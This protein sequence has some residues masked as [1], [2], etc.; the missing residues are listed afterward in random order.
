MESSGSP[1]YKCS[2][3]CSTLKTS[4]ASRILTTTGGMREGRLE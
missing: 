1:L 4:T 2:I 3:S